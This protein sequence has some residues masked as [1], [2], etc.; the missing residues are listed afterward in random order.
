MEIGLFHSSKEKK[1]NQQNKKKGITYQIYIHA[2]KTPQ[3]WSLW[4]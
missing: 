2:T 4:K 3:V 1:K